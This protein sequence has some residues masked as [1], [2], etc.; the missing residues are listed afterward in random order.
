[1]KTQK[2]KEKCF[3]IAGSK[4]VSGSNGLKLSHALVLHLWQQD[5]H[6][7]VELGEKYHFLDHGKRSI[8]TISLP[9]YE[10]IFKD[11]WCRII[12][13]LHSHTMTPFDAPGKQAF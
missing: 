3:N 12:L 5:L 11:T 6:E 9:F 2:Q 1:M 4:F 10:N 7:G 13:M 8:V